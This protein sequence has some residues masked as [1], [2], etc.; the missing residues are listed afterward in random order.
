LC[1]AKDRAI[2]EFIEYY[3]QTR[4][5]EGIGNVGPAIDALERTTHAT[6]TGKRRGRKPGRRMSAAGRARIS[7]AQ[8]KRWAER[9]GKKAASTPKKTRQGG[10]SAAGRK[11]I[12]EMMKQ[13][14]A[15]RKKSA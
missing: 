8:K 13:R 7:A 15:A 2:A 10:I 1:C 11:R 3:N 9:K 4:Y 12:S 6:S 5:H 14:W